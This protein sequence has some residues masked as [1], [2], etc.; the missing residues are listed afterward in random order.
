MAILYVPFSF[1]KKLFIYSAL[2][3]RHYWER[4]A[5]SFLISSFFFFLLN[6]ILC[7]K[8]K[9]FILLPCLSFCKVSSVCVCLFY[10]YFSLAFFLHNLFSTYRN[11]IENIR[12]FFSSSSSSSDEYYYLLLYEH[13]NMFTHMFL[14]FYFSVSS[15]LESLHSH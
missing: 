7:S 2:F 13:S 4:S 14:F 9:S 5:S 1:E 10:N 11:Y 3:S 6:F 15:V 12:F 8:R